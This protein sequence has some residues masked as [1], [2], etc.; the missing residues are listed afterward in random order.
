MPYLPGRAR[1]AYSADGTDKDW[2]D[3]VLHEY[4]QVLGIKTEP[5]I[6]PTGKE[7][8]TAVHNRQV[9]SIFNSGI[10]SDYPHPE[11]YLV[12]GYASSQADGKGL[13]NGDYK[14]A[15]YDAILSRAA[16]KTDQDEAMQDYRQAE[17][18]L[19]K[20]LP[21]LPLWYRKVSAV[22]GKQVRQAPFGY[23]GLPV[24]NQVTK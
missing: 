7:F 1:F 8:N 4:A 13:N 24:Y 15:E 21:V 11:G 17:S 16:S 10:T 9:N 23:M 5:N 3:A 20:D 12:Q 2:V 22:A 18:V 6:F 14:S 19:F